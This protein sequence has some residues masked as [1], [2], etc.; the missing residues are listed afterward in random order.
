M[1]SKKTI[2]RRHFLQYLGLS[3]VSIASTYTGLGA[4]TQR[5]SA[6]GTNDAYEQLPEIFN[7]TLHTATDAD[8]LLLSNGFSYGVLA[9]YGDTINNNGDTFG[10]N[11][12]YTSFFPFPNSSKEAFLWVN[13][14]SAQY[15]WL[16]DRSKSIEWKQQKQLLYDQGG[17]LLHVKKDAF[18]S[19]KLV[20]DSPLARRITGLTPIELT[21]PARGTSAVN[22]GTLV[23]GTFANRG[24]S[25]TLWNTQLTGENYFE[26]TCR[27]AGLALSHYGWIVEIDPFNN[28]R[29]PVKHTALGRFHHGS[30]AMTINASNQVVVYMGEDS[31]SG[32]VYKFVSKGTWRDGQDTENLLTEG[33]LYAADFIQGRWV[34]LSL[35]NVRKML[36]SFTYQAPES[37]YKSK[38]VLLAQFASQSDVL[39]YANEAAQIIGATP[40]DRPA[41]LTLHPTDKSVYIAYTQ[42][43]SRGNLHGQIVRLKEK[44]STSFEFETFLAGGRQSGFSSPASLTFDRNGNLWVGSDLSPDQLNTGAWS[45][46]KNN[47]MYLIH[48]SGAAN[49][50][51]QLASAP[52]EAALSGVSFTELQDTIFLTVNHPGSTGAETGKPTSQWQ[53]KFGDQNPR[54][55][56]VTIT[57]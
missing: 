51:K 18:G 43:T 6:A 36:T 16:M 1:D 12:S 13:H 44:G 29:K 41:V 38:E 23:Q 14:E 3:A 34:E 37:M 47:G 35:S 21:G 33:I 54:S 28:K 2:S 24:G 9:A 7:P 56:V 57:R 32:F 49:L 26:A 40:C 19:W 39:T 46:F 50:T 42:N 55:A 53:H 8:Q 30:T 10:F 11:S 20:D 15:P 22:G 52:T 25:K 17:S 48:R 45:E 4:F 31:P 27:D 5:A